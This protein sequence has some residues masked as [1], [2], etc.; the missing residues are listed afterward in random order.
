MQA[1]EVETLLVLGANPAYDA[2][3]RPSVSPAALARVPFSVHPRPLRRRDRAALRLARA[4]IASDF[5]RW[6][7]LRA[8]DGTATFSSR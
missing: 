5:E 3:S 1:G 8:T 4:G 6:S 7:D 2:P